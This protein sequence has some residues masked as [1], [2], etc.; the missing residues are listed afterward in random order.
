M[1]EFLMALGLIF[2]AELTDS[3]RPGLKILGG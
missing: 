1:Q 3:G 2:L